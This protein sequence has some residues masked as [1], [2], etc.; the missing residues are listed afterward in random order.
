MPANYLH[1]VEAIE[2]DAGIRPVRTVK[3]A[4]IGL[5]GT[6]PKGPVHTPT[7]I[8]SEQQ[9]QATFGDLKTQAAEGYSIPEALDAIYDQGAGTVLVV[10]V[11]DPSTHTTNVVAEAK[12]FGADDTLTLAHNDVSAVV[13]KSQDGLTTYVVGVDYTVDAAT[14]VLTRVAGGAIP[15]QGQVKVDYTYADVTKVLAADL[16]GVAGPPRTGMQAWLDCQGLFGFKPK[17]LIAPEWSDQA[18]VRAELIVKAGALRAIA[19]VDV[20]QGQTPQQVLA[21]RG[22]GQPLNS[23]SPRVA[24]CYP[25]VKV[26]DVAGDEVLQPFSGRLAG[27]IA[28]KDL[29]QG[30]WWSPSNSEIQGIVGMERTLTADI[31]DPNAEVNLLNEQGIVTIFNAYAT[32]Y[33]TWGN[34]SA[35]WPSETKP[36]NFLN[37]RRVADILHESIEVSMLPFLDRPIVPALIDEIVASVNAFIRTLIGRG[38]LVEGSCRYDVADNPATEVALGHLTFRL[39][40]MPPTP[41]ERISFESFIDISLLKT[42]G[43]AS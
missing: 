29:A 15:A 6:A 43:V 37:V 30:Y 16:V 23:A 21:A 35:A 22:A 20:A 17:I 14:G 38:A 3:T 40:F 18:A 4:V 7:L 5:V 8:L 13:V 28:A 9:A 31:A 19:L 10:N 27:V 41:A 26:V 2:I 1:G 24:F 36:I 39:D 11:F 32:G 25:H 42:A 34:R 33:R 12:A